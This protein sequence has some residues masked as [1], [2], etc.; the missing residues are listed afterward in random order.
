MGEEGLAGVKY[1]FEKMRW[2]LVLLVCL[3]V[4]IFLVFDRQSREHEIENA[5]ARLKAFAQL[6]AEQSS[7][8]LAAIDALG[9]EVATELVRE[10]DWRAW[11]EGRGHELLKARKSQTLPQLRDIAVFDA[12]G[13]QRLHSTF[14]PAEPIRIVDRPYFGVLRDGARR[15]LWGPY[16]GRNSGLMTYAIAHRIER[17]GEFGGVVLIA[18]ELAYFQSFCWNS[19]HDEDLQAFIVNAGG[20]IVAECR[21]PGEFL[22]GHSGVGTAVTAQLPAQM[23]STSWSVEQDRLPEHGVLMSVRPISHF[24]DLSVVAVLPEAIALR[25]WETDRTRNAI[26][27]GVSLLLMLAGLRLIFVQIKRQNRIERQLQADIEKRRE[28]E[29]R[30]QNLI[31]T[32]SDWV[33]EVNENGVYTYASPKVA[34][35]FGHA[36]EEVLGKT[37]FDFMPPDEAARVG[38][39]FGG[40]L[41][42]RQPIIRLE[43]VNRHREGHL[44]VIETSGVPIFDAAGNFR[45]YR[46]MDR[47]ITE[48]KRAEAELRDSHEKL[49]RLV[50]E[51]TR[52]LVDAK[53]RAESAILAKS[54]FLTNMSHELRTPMH[55]IMGMTTLA[56]RGIQDAKTLGY[57]DK[58]EKASERLLHI[59]DDI[60]NVAAFES[61]GQ[62]VGAERLTLD[63]V[64][65]AVS[66]RVAG[67]A[68][69]KKLPF[70]VELPEA[71][72]QLPLLGDIRHLCQVLDNLAGNAVKFTGHGGV[73][74]RVIL[75][76]ESD[77]LMHLRFE[78]CD[79]GIGIAA[80]DVE[81][82]F[83]PFEQVDGS[84]TRQYGGTGLGLAISERLVHLMGG[85]IGVSS[86]P[87][88][89]STF[90]V[91]L[92][93]KRAEP[94]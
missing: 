93:L 26:V 34:S 68:E 23:P 59:I 6:H 25:D 19:K 90:W 51:R 44:I 91:T 40:I 65:N 11:P 86:Q 55:A 84:M 14:L 20:T 82:L 9:Q 83:K 36:P 29:V 39:L 32:T 45:G 74:C 28:T 63:Q 38:A 58:A 71:L 62:T 79:T 80:S 53:E 17:N 37:P 1:R 72:G 81:R 13:V 31:D 46:G 64:F 47:D 8:A 12:Q 48:R 73:I 56:R 75:L 41:A 69:E 43:N 92:G 42:N 89:G 30:L 78:V 60:L 88:V 70:S 57:L 87:G 85:E 15:A 61:E 24:P 10:G 52:D 67:R 94:V 77:G 3:P 35:L 49:E 21:P 50:E 5:G 4:A 18:V 16:K 2:L 33:W 76:G 22:S 7:R 27:L 54:T 66:S